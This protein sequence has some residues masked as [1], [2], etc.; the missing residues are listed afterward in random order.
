MSSCSRG[1]KCQKK[2]LLSGDYESKKYDLVLWGATGFTGQVVAAYLARRYGVTMPW[3][4]AGRNAHKLADVCRSLVALDPALAD[5]RD[6][7]V[8][9]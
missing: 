2:R 3:A 6:R 8:H 7:A 4:I 5:S 9:G 1:A